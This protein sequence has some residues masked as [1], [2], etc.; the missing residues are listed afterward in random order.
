MIR[1][2]LKHSN[3]VV[4][5]AVALVAFHALT[6]KQLRALMLTDISDGRL[7][8]GDREIPLARH[9]PDPQALREDRIL[10]EIHATGGDVR[11]V[12]DL[13]GRSVEAPPATSRP[14]STPISRSIG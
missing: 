13:F 2:E 11:R 12:C 4:A 1:A 7:T 10:H 6:G 3:P 8:I 9:H 14:S 5:L